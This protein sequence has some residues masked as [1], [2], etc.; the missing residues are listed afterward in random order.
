MARGGIRY[1]DR[2]DDFRT[3]VLGLVN[4]QMVKNSVIVPAGSKGG[5]ITLHESEDPGEMAMEAKAQYKTLI[6]GMLDVTDNIAVDGSYLPPS[7]VVCWDGVDPY[8]VVAADKG[9]SKYS[10]TAND[11]ANEYNFWLGDASV[12]YTHLTLPTTPYV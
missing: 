9:T 8:L 3:E 5:F 4:T 11:V 6:R 10:D 2:P 7:G 12:S 1:S